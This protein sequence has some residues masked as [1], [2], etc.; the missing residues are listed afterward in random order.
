MAAK[1]V[2]EKR[3]DENDKVLVLIDGHSVMF[4]AFFALP[5]NLRSP[6]GR[7]TNAITGFLSIILSVI[8]NLNPHAL[9]CVFDKGKPQ[10]R[11]ELL[12]KYKAQR[13]KPDPDLLAQFEPIQHLLS[14]ALH[15]PVIIQE[16]WE[17]D[18]LLGTLSTRARQQGFK[19]Y[20]VTGD[21]DSFQLINEDVRVYYAQKGSPQGVIYDEERVFEIFQVYPSQIPDY[22]GLKGDTSDNIPGVSGVGEKTAAKLIETYG[23]IE[24]IYEHIDEIKGKTR[25]NLEAHQ[26]DAFI[27]R[28]VATISREV[29]LEP[30]DFESLNFPAF[31]IEEMKKDFDELGLF[32]QFKRFAL[33][34]SSDSSK[35]LKEKSKVT[36]FSG[37]LISQRDEAFAALESAF[38]RGLYLGLYYEEDKDGEKSTLFSDPRLYVSCGNDVLVFRSDSLVKAL[39][40][41][42]QHGRFACLGLKSLMQLLIPGDGSLP[43]QLKTGELSLK[44][45][46]DLELMAYLLDSGRSSYEPAQLLE[47]Y[48]QLE[49][50]DPEEQKPLGAYKAAVCAY[51]SPLMKEKLKQEESFTC[52]TMIELP[53]T[54]ALLNLER[55]GMALDTELLAEL[56][57]DAR[58][59]INKMSEGIFALAGEEFN[60]DSPKQLSTILYEKL[61]LTP[62]KKTKT[63]YST[64]AATLEK[65]IAEHEIVPK[66]IE[67]REFSKLKSTYLDALP[68]LL[69]GDRRVHTQFNQTVASTGRLSSSH[70]NLQNIPVRTE[71]GRQIRRA[72]VVD[73]GKL[74]VSFDYSQIE[75]RLLA[76]LSQDENLIAAFGQG[77]DFHAATA[78]RIFSVELDEVSPEMR[79]RAK[80]VNFG[81]VYGQQ[82]YGLSQSLGISM[83]E[84]QEMITRYF[85]AYPRVRAYL[86]ELVET[87]RT[88]GF[89]ET[90][91]GRKRHIPDIK[92]ARPQARGFAERTAMNHPM[93]GSAADIIKLAMIELDKRLEESGLSARMIVQVHDELDFECPQ[94][95]LGQ[96]VALVKELMET[97][98]R[99]D[100][101]LLVEVSSAANWAEAK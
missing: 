81:I 75:L 11:I 69:A 63:G 92:S 48:A 41:I 18:D 55:T 73:E 99:L 31:N 76:H 28:E 61:K 20:L 64:D 9:V 95:E 45:C 72:F 66:I 42:V 6:D 8:E 70:P 80:A 97:V 60:I 83:V 36:L 44:R 98:V 29:P 25:K 3:F 17:G 16:G 87:A 53:L 27:S 38:A 90:M 32:T 26:E 56:S 62:G 67:Y 82:A 40:K 15:I 71:H 23:S 1:T 79:S 5:S 19:T 68:R 78:A 52:Y 22:Y 49:M 43:A 13:K 93:Q 85:Q 74:F 37:K 57:Q 2:M 84:A 54:C 91:F 34:A 21:R 7:P 100:V 14:S 77:E 33:L 35:N 94:E 10:K 65:L 101:P 58:V 51:L 39:L 50:P 59:H 30:L 4:R 12:K 86:N 24:N 88:Q 89:V 47:Q 96:L 46:D